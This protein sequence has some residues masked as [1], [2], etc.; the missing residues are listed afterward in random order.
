M[1]KLWEMSEAGQEHLLAVAEEVNCTNGILPEKFIEKLK[2]NNGFISSLHAYGLDHKGLERKNPVIV[3]LGDS[4][5]GGHFENLFKERD[6]IPEMIAKNEPISIVDL[7]KVYH[8]QFRLML[9]E[10]LK[11]TSLSIINAGIAGDT[12]LGMEKRL[13]RD[14]IR[15]DP[16]LVIINGTLNWYTSDGEPYGTINDFQRSLE[17]IVQ[18]IK[19]NSEADLILLTPNPI[20]S[21][22][23]DDTLYQRVQIVRNT[24]EKEQVSLVDVYKL[25]TELKLDDDELKGY[26]SNKINHPTPIGHTLYAKALMQL[27]ENI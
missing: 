5:T 15:Y 25:W 11:N 12:I 27:F 4:V 17:R 22:L 2:T 1:N 8:E 13:Y 18:T 21:L 24:A 7:H 20:T 26:M 9:A 23:K 6:E 16:D 3:A 14:V 19:Q 10:K